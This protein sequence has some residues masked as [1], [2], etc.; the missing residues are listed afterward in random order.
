MTTNTIAI[1]VADAFIAAAKGSSVQE[2]LE[3]G[4]TAAL[5]AAFIACKTQ[6]EF[7]SLFGTGGNNKLPAYVAGEIDTAFRAKLA[8]QIPTVQKRALAHFKSEMSNYRKVKSLGLA[9]G[10]KGARATLNEHRKEQA[11]ANP[12]AVIDTKPE[13]PVST[14][15]T[16]LGKT[17]SM[18]DVSNFVSAYVAHHGM[19]ATR[20]LAAQLRDFMPITVTKAKQAV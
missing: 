8:K 16:M 15:W 19:T 12:P 13:T 20:A 18:E 17:A 4:V 7:L 10:D 3:L 2:K 1:N 14:D 11:K 5:K 9:L 6:A